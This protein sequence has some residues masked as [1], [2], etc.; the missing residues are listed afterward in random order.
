MRSAGL[1]V[2]ILPLVISHFSRHRIYKWRT[3]VRELV[4]P[5]TSKPQR[6]DNLKISEERRQFLLRCGKFSAVTPPAMALLLA[7]SAVPEEAAAS[8]WHHRRGN[9]EGNRGGNGG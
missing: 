1:T 4:M 6:P 2:R 3:I 9:G 5:M 7:V 8:S